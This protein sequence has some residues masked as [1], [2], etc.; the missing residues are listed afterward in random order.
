M[1]AVKNAT[2]DLPEAKFDGKLYM[3]LNGNHF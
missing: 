3:Y 1:I 2:G